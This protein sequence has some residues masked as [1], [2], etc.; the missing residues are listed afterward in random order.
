MSGTNNVWIT[1]HKTVPGAKDRI[2]GCTAA[3]RF[4]GEAAGVTGGTRVFVMGNPNYPYHYWRSDL[5]LHVSAG[6]AYFPDT[7][8]EVLDQNSDAITAAGQDGRA[9][10]RIQGE[11]SVRHRL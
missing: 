5:G 11:L 8:E 9:A 6:M 2:T 3:V 1:A 10:D 7:A 4:G